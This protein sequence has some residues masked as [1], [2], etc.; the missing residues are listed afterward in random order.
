M[1]ALIAY[2][3]SAITYAIGHLAYVI[4]L[5]ENANAIGG[6]LPWAGITFC[7]LAFF[8]FGHFIAKMEPA[9]NRRRTIR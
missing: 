6:W 2:C 7:P 5:T 3:L 8:Y 4:C 1:K 9:A